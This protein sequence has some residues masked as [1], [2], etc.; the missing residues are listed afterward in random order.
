MIA[1]LYRTT[2]SLL[3]FFVEEIA[4]TA[5]LNSKAQTGVANRTPYPSQNSIGTNSL[6]VIKL[7]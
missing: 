6:P 1:R 5:A 2:K 7:D 3:A 4:D